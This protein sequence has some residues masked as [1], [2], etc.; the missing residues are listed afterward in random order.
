MSHYASKMKKK[1]KN[2]YERS[3]TVKVQKI[4]HFTGLYPL[5]PVIKSDKSLKIVST[6]LKIHISSLISFQFEAHSKHLG[7]VDMNSLSLSIIFK[8]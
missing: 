3:K 8:S 6:D 2:K 7:A 5:I 4:T 1:I